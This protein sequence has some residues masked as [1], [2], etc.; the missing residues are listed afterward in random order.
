[1]SDVD[2]VADVNESIA[3]L[4]REYPDVTFRVV[5]RQVPDESEELTHL[6]TRTGLDVY[7]TDGPTASLVGA[8]LRPFGQ[9]VLAV[10][11]RDVG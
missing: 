2:A 11:P 4:G 8:L 5:A 6:V 3:A 1:M 10:L 7:W 9:V